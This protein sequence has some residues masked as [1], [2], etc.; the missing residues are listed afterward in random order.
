MGDLNSPQVDI[1][2]L[3]G[4]LNDLNLVIDW[5]CMTSKGEIKRRRYVPDLVEAMA[6]CDANYIRLMK[7]FGWNMD[8]EQIAFGI[9]HEEDDQTLIEMAVRERCPYTTMLELRVTND[10]D[11]PWIRW[12]S[13]E[14]RIY[15]DVCSAEVVSFE[16]HKRIR[17][18]YDYPNPEMY[19]PDEKSQ[20]NKYLGELLTFCINHGH[21]LV[22]ISAISGTSIEVSK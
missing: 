22:E 4:T 3:C 8:A 1:S 13:M 17:Y 2:F 7:L 10:E 20:I 12:P 14:I 21:S 5:N 9:A 15:H 16:R 6:D 19:L 11:K 18:R